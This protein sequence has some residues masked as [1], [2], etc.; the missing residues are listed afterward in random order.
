MLLLKSRVKKLDLQ[1]SQKLQQSKRMK[2]LDN[3]KYKDK[4]LKQKQRSVM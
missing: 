1:L 2:D 4:E 3:G